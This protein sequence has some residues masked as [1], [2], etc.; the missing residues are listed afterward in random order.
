MISTP[1]SHFSGLPVPDKCL[2]LCSTPSRNQGRKGKTG[3]TCSS[4]RQ[5]QQS[6]TAKNVHNTAALGIRV[7]PAAAPCAER[8]RVAW[9]VRRQ[10][11]RPIAA[12]PPA[13]GKTRALAEVSPAAWPLRTGSQPPAERGSY[14]CIR[15][16]RSYCW[17]R[18]GKRLPRPQRGR[19]DG[20]GGQVTLAECGGWGH[21]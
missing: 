8:P 5:L 2:K 10:P 7:N 6:E 1:P 12:W 16:T 17:G 11:S 4:G 20:Q 15:P 21:G 13:S 19:Q 18:C 9:T 14:V 3:P